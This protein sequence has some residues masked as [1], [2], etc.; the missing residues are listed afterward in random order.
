VGRPLPALGAVSAAQRYRAAA[1]AYLVYGLVYLAGGLYLLSQGVGV[2]GSRAG[3]APEAAML[4]WGLVG[5]VPLGMI[6]VLL[7]WPWSW[8]G[9]VLSRR[10]FAWVVAAL[11]TVR[12]VKVGEIAVRGGGAV[13]APWGGE[14]T[15]QAG[16]VVF[17]AVTLVALAFV[18]RAAWGGE[19]PAERPA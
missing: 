12:A 15:F 5:L 7:A 4:R 1:L 14:V 2:A 19:G 6:P 10:V 3:A 13:A 8:L 16:A 18:V 9:G 11:L 17:L